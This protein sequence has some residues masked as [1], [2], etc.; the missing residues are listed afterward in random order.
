MTLSAAPNLMVLA[1]LAAGTS[2]Y[3]DKFGFFTLEDCEADS[4]EPDWSKSLTPDSTAMINRFNQGL[5]TPVPI[6]ILCKTPDA[7]QVFKGW[8]QNLV[9]KNKRRETD[10]VMFETVKGIGKIKDSN[11]L[12]LATKLEMTVANLRRHLLHLAEHNHIV[13]DAQAGYYFAR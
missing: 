11:L 8:E 10:A 6:R 2:V 3:A 1:L 7:L 4:V 12:G 13:F 5:S 9:T